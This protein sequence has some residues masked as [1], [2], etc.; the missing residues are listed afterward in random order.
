MTGTMS[1]PSGNPG[2]NRPGDNDTLEV[3]SI[4][5]SEIQ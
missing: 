5:D 2:D 4:S 1:K 3:L